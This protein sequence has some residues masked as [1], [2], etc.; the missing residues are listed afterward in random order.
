MTN[1]R[2]KKVALF[3]MV[4]CGLLAIQS[5]FVEQNIFQ[6][7]VAISSF[8]TMHFAYENP[9]LLMSSSWKEFGERADV[10]K[11]KEKLTGTPWYFAAVFFAILYIILV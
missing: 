10:A 1:S 8:F 4:I 5:T 7:L 3:M 2:A 6:S 9:E 11:G